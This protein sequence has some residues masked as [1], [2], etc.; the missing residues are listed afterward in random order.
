MFE[1]GHPAFAGRLFVFTKRRNQSVFAAPFSD[2]R[3]NGSGLGT[4]LAPIRELRSAET[5]C[6]APAIP[7]T[8]L[9]RRLSLRRRASGNARRRE[10]SSAFFLGGG[11][12]LFLDLDLLEGVLQICRCLLEL[13]ELAATCRVRATSGGPKM[14]S[15]IARSS[16]SGMPMEPNILSAPLLG[17]GR[18]KSW[19]HRRISE[20]RPDLAWPTPPAGGA[21]FAVP[22]LCARG[23]ELPSSMRSRSTVAAIVAILVS[24]LVG[25]VL[26]KA[27]QLAGADRCRL[28]IGTYTAA[29]TAIQTQYAEPVEADRMVYS[30]IDGVLQRGSAFELHGPPDLR[31]NA[32]AEEGP[33]YGLGLTISFGRR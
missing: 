7:A 26:R 8:V 2:E 29:L 22:A 24:A 23:Q 19:P 3:R 5:G 31:A 21:F 11:F 25:G 4:G 12:L 17:S 16:H 33:Y 14:M 18:P 32:R 1:E 9:R 30:S 13:V 6:V 15:A 10:T 28:T 20:Y 27:A